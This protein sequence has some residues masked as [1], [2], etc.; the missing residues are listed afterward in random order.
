MEFSP[1]IEFRAVVVSGQLRCASDIAVNVPVDQLI[2]LWDSPTWGSVD[3][4]SICFD[5]INV[6]KS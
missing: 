6:P 5:D 1:L 3:G 4:I 2:D